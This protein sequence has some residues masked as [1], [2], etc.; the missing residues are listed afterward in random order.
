[1]AMWPGAVSD[2]ATVMLRWAL[3]P[4]LLNSPTL[5]SWLSTPLVR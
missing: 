3:I 1:M 4:R 5:L 2:G